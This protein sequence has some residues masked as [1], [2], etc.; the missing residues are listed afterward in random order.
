M[1]SFVDGLF[2]FVMAGALMATNCYSGESR[3]QSPASIVAPFNV[4]PVKLAL[5]RSAFEK[6]E[7]VR[8]TFVRFA[9]LR[10]V[11]LKFALAILM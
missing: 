1:K 10:S 9:L 4:A 2:A 7:F 8:S 6:S 11:F 3:S 5:E